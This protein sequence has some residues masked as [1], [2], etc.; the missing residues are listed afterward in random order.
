VRVARGRSRW[1]WQS[2]LPMDRQARCRAAPL[3]RRGRATGW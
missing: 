1:L 3:R 2:I